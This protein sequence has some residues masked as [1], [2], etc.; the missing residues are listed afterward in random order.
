M[1]TCM[2]CRLFLY[3]HC[4]PQGTICPVVKYGATR[5]QLAGRHHGWMQ[6]GGICILKYGYY[7]Q[8]DSCMIVAVSPQIKIWKSEGGDGEQVDS[9]EATRT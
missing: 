1:S 5:D 7:M 2:L 4:S 3:V 8:Y 9:A 6:C